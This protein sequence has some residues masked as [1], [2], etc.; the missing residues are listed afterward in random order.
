VD[1]AHP[2]THPHIHP[3]THTR[4]QRT[5]KLGVD[6]IAPITHLHDK[7]LHGAG[8][9]VPRH[10]RARDR[11]V[12][13]RADLS[14]ACAAAW[15]VL[16]I[17]FLFAMSTKESSALHRLQTGASTKPYLDTHPSGLRADEDVGG[18]EPAAAAHALACRG[19]EQTADRASAVDFAALSFVQFCFSLP[20]LSLSLSLSLSQ[21]TGDTKKV[22]RTFDA[23]LFAIDLQQLDD[24]TAMQRKVVWPMGLRMQ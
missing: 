12:A 7:L 24:I 9:V 2:R 6:T 22:E 23:R 16:Q 19:R 1:R 21:Y 4:T 15:R 10:R 5:H 17:A 20:L 18:V 3:H 8:A 14:L 13:R 11:R